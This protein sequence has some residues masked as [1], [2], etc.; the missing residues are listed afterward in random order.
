L[1]GRSDG[2]SIKT[3]LGQVMPRK[4]A[5]VHG[6]ADSIEHLSNHVN[7]TMKGMCSQVITPKKGEHVYMTSD[8][9]IYQMKLRDALFEKLNFRK[10]GEY[11]ISWV[12][13]Q[14]SFDGEDNL[15]MLNPL[16]SSAIVGHSPVFLGDVK[17]SNFKRILEKAG[18]K[19][20]LGAG[21]LVANEVVA[22][23]KAEDG[24]LVL[25]GCI[26]ETYYRVRELLYQQ[27]HLL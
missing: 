9:S 20:K 27:F 21:T 19:T 1:E 23:R 3:L 14:V 17:L 18:F 16:P 2:R 5:L 26:S 6:S 12:D 4:L 8:T 7:T 22:V 10:L 25:E 15:P 13:G 11:D 24:E